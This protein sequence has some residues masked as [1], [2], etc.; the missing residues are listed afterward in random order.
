M[1][2][3]WNMLKKYFSQ[4]AN[5][6]KVNQEFKEVIKKTYQ[7]NFSSK[8]Q[9]IIDL[10]NYL[11][12]NK[13]KSSV[14]PYYLFDEY[15]KRSVV[16]N[17]DSD[18]NLPFVVHNNRRLYFPKSFGFEK[19]RKLYNW[20][21]YEQDPSSPHSYL[22]NNFTLDDN[23]I[24][25]DIGSAEGIFTLNNI[26]HIKHAYLFESEKYWIEPLKATFKEWS[27]KVTITHALV[28]AESSETQI[29]LDDFFCNTNFSDRIFVKM[30]VEGYEEQV[31]SGATRLLVNP[32]IK[33]K[34]AIATYHRHNQF[35]SI[36][37][38]MKNLNYFS[39]PSKGYILFYYDEDM[40]PPYLRK[41][42]L[43]SKNH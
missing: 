3:N 33:I 24:L 18:L 32:K 38:F 37:I 4:I 17:E 8:D 13:W 19:I 10:M 27:D 5:A 9:E 1:K 26:E 15:I 42:V 39:E 22:S 23:S 20:L 25:I 36:N 11:K 12:F 7:Y 2:M 16:I 29:S 31:L 35:D 41:C 14:F 40:R 21:C 30:D 28:S 6:I 43:Y 34:T